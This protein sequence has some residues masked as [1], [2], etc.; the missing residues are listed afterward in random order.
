MSTLRATWSQPERLVLGIV[1]A[2]VVFASAWAVVHA[3]SL[4]PTPIVDT[5][6]YRHY[7]ALVREGQVPYR[8]FD[9]EYPPGALPTFVAPTFFGDYDDS[10]DLMMAA[11]GLS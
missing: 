2:M 11:L 5:P 7:G 4:E 9:V 3:A 1:A 10:F 6:T 8:D